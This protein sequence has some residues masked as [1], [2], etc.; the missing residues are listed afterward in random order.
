[1]RS[2]LHMTT[3]LLAVAATGLLNIT[4]LPEVVKVV[5]QDKGKLSKAEKKRERKAQKRLNHG[6]T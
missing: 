6:N 4:P 2:R 1:M 3:M 5:P